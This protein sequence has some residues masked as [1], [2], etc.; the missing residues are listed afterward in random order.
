MV[1]GTDLQLG[2]SLNVIG[3]VLV[4]MGTNFFKASIDEAKSTKHYHGMGIAFFSLGSF[5]NFISFAYASQTALAALGGVQFVSNLACGHFILRE[6]VSRQHIVA[7]LI[8]VV[9]VFISVCNAS[10]ESSGMLDPQAILSLYDA[11]YFRLLITLVSVMGACEVLYRRYEDQDARVLASIQQQLPPQKEKERLVLARYPCAFLL[12]PLTFAIPSA[13]LGTQAALQGKCMSGLI[14]LACKTND[15]KPLMSFA[16][17]LSL[18]IF[19][20]CLTGWLTRLYRALQLFDGLLIIPL[21]Q[22]CWIVMAVLQGGTFFKE[23]TDDLGLFFAGIALLL[24]GVFVLASAYSNASATREAGGEA[25]VNAEECN[26]SPLAQSSKKLCLSPRS[27]MFHVG[28]SQDLTS[29]VAGFPLSSPM[30]VQG[31]RFPDRRAEW[32]ALLEG[33]AE[34]SLHSEK[35]TA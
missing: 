20:T 4:N 7:V 30:R 35:E 8:L 11:T 10:A 21:L 23:F 22:T 31:L 2:V 34:P 5:A 12:K 24:L 33:S 29:L 15:I 32:H 6:E 13:V 9:G 25:E 3:S 27:Y 17:V 28:S 14:R 19:C 1:M 16:S 18:G 26:G